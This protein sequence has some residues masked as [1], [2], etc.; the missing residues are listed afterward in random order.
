MDGATGRRQ[1]L[2]PHL[3]LPRVPAGGGSGECARCR[4]ARQCSGGLGPGAGIASALAQPVL[5]RSGASPP[6]LSRLSVRTD[7]RDR[8]LPLE[9]RVQHLVDGFGH[10]LGTLH[11]DEVTGAVDRAHLFAGPRPVGRA[12]HRPPAGRSPVRLR[13]RPFGASSKTD[14]SISTTASQRVR[15]VSTRASTAKA[16]KECATHTTGPRPWCCPRPGRSVNAVSTATAII[17]VRCGK[18]GR[19]GQRVGSIITTSTSMGSS[20]STSSQSSLRPA[21]P[22]TKTMQARGDSARRPKR[23]WRGFWSVQMRRRRRPCR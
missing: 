6:E 5:G 20:G 18:L 7:G 14:G 11:H 22:A 9:H 15:P 8:V 1:F 21:S 10:G 3:C 12:S 13:P 19:S 23:F 2:R 17:A 16:A 4:V